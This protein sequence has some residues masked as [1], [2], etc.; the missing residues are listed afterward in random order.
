MGRTT[1]MSVGTVH[2]RHLGTF[3]V[4]QREKRGSAWRVEIEMLDG[5]S[6]GAKL[7]KFT[8]QLAKSA[9]K[10][11]SA[12]SY[13]PD[14]VRYTDEGVPVWGNLSPDAISRLQDEYDS[15][16]FEFNDDEVARARRAW[17]HLIKEHGEVI[18]GDYPKTLLNFEFFLEWYAWE[19]E[20]CT[21][22]HI[23]RYGADTQLQSRL[24]VAED[25]FTID[26]KENP[27]SIQMLCSKEHVK[28]RAAQ[29]SNTE[30]T[31]VYCVWQVGQLAAVLDDSKD[32]FRQM[33]YKSGEPRKGMDL[34]TPAMDPNYY[35][36]KWMEDH[37]DDPR[38]ETSLF[39]NDF[40]DDDE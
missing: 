24:F 32:E 25:V 35:T 28:A 5:K 30:L 19:Y 31:H 6:K 23:R 7:W 40:E 12:L 22:R 15:L 16:M 17:R 9:E 8:S 3:R 26:P 14:A 21:L 20:Q 38:W 36:C 4:L 1:D 33:Y 29:V 13:G 2:T 39:A 11:P 18:E 37:L 27:N 10:E 34:F